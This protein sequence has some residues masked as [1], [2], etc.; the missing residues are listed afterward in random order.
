MA[1]DAFNPVHPR[2]GGRGE[3]HVEALVRLKSRLLALIENFRT[4]NSLYWVNF[5]SAATP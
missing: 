3:M 4:P 5:R 2:T 1:E